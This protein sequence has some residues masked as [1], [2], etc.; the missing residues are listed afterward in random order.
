MFRYHPMIT[1]SQ[2]AGDRERMEAALTGLPEV[3]AL[4]VDNGML[5]EQMMETLYHHNLGS[6]FLEMQVQESQELWGLEDTFIP[7]SLIYGDEEVRVF[8]PWALF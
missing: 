3:Q 4:L 7:S 2:T 1:R 5:V 6:R 8:C